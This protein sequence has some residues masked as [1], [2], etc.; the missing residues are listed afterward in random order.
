MLQNVELIASFWT[1]AG[2]GEPDTDRDYSSFDF[3]DR[4]EAAA[5]ACFK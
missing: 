3:K 5:K 4:V 1:L 2:K